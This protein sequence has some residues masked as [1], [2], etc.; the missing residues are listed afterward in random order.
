MNYTI[1][2]DNFQKKY[3]P[4][5]TPERSSCIS[6]RINPGCPS[7]WRDSTPGCIERCSSVPHTNPGLSVMPTTRSCPACS[8]PPRPFA[9]PCGQWG[10]LL[11]RSIQDLESP[12]VTAPPWFSPVYSLSS[13]RS[14]SAFRRDNFSPP[15]SLWT[16]VPPQLERFEFLILSEIKFPW[17]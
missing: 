12:P 13:L 6:Y 5:W 9:I 15:L 17:R 1:S 14:A 7:T 10:L 11:D 2:P 3:R 4:S 8:D 16:A